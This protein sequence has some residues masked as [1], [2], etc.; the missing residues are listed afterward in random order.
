MHLFA[1]DAAFEA[2]CVEAALSVMRDR[3]A[4]HF[5]INMSDKRYLRT[6]IFSR[7]LLPQPAQ[8]IGGADSQPDSS[9][10]YIHQQIYSFASFHFA[11]ARRTASRKLRPLVL[12]SS[13]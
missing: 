8:P 3:F 2:C 7:I 5:G 4:R 1:L 11:A 10:N 12:I 13:Q 9:E 6:P